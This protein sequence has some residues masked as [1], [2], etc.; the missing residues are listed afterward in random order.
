MSSPWKPVIASALAFGLGVAATTAYRAVPEPVEEVEPAAEAK[1]AD[2]ARDLAWRIEDG[3]LRLQPM[4]PEKTF[5]AVASAADSPGWILALAPGRESSLPL[6]AVERLTVA[7]VTSVAEWRDQ[8]MLPC[9][10]GICTAPPPPD[11]T[12][13]GGSIYQGTICDPGR[14]CA[15][16]QPFC[17][18]TGQCSG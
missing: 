13:S 6:A 8:V 1:P 5:I 4:S 7:E 9:K 2:P 17:E 14:S 16:Q 12:A 15:G 11:A 10:P 3:I 18:T